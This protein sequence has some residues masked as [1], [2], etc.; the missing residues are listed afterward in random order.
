MNADF[1]RDYARWWWS[2][3]AGRPGGSA[4][5]A[6]RV[7]TQLVGPWIGMCAAVNRVH[8]RLHLAPGEMLALSAWAGLRLAP[9]VTDYADAYRKFERDPGAL[10]RV[11][12]C[13]LA[14]IAREAAFL[15]RANGMYRGWHTRAAELWLRLR[16]LAGCVCPLMPAL[17]TALWRAL[18][19]GGTPKWPHLR[20]EFA[21]LPAPLPD[22]PLNPV[23]APACRGANPDGR[24]Q[25]GIILHAGRT[26]WPSV[27]PSSS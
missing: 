13:S 21:V 18:Q 22:L 25:A 12:A 2:S 24:A 19:I 6:A 7:S 5:F 14:S 11:I 23:I 8:S 26:T 4:E 20:I 9:E 1:C 10:A 16:L 17:G 15:G 27:R 3:S